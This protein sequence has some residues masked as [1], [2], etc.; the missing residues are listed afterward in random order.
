MAEKV[1]TTVYLEADVI[2]LARLEN[3]NLSGIINS[4]LIEYFKADNIKQLEDMAKSL[5]TQL[6]AVNK[7]IHD[8]IQKGI[9][10]DRKNN[11]AN[12]IY[13]EL[14]SIFQKRKEN[15]GVYDEANFQEWIHTPKNRERCRLIGKEPLEVLEQLKKEAGISEK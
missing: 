4:F 3:A 9:S 6:E 14:V 10:T 15:L 5:E 7:R 8:L 2:H 1:R 11:M 12:N 13:S